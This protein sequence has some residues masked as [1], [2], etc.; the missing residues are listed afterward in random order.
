[1][2]YFDLNLSKEGLLYLDK[3]NLKQIHFMSFF[4]IIIELFMLLFGY[5]VKLPYYYLYSYAILLIS[6]LF[7]YFSTYKGSP[8]FL[9]QIN[10]F[11]E[12]AIYAFTIWGVIVAAFDVNRGYSPFVYLINISFITC[13]FIFRPISA[14]LYSLI[15][16][17]IFSLVF[18]YID[19]LTI[20]IIV[21][22]SLFHFVMF[23]I[24]VGR[25]RA[26]ESN[27][28]D[29]VNL[30]KANKELQILSTIDQLSGCKNRRGLNYEIKKYENQVVFA[31]LADIDN[32]K[33]LNDNYGHDIG[34]LFLS[35]FAKILQS[36]F[37]VSNVFRIGGDEFFIITNS[38]TLQSC[39]KKFE[40]SR[41]EISSISFV[42]NTEL[43]ITISAGYTYKVLSG[44]DG[45]EIMYKDLDIALYKSKAKGKN[46]VTKADDYI[47]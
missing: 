45:F 47:I 29:K 15:N 4:V 43:N 28:K 11:L 38:E 24:C 8:Q 44:N 21:N 14:L 41:K 12:I 5:I 17:T 25:Y 46:Y 40:I 31:L 36:N 23:L 27:Y 22:F 20:D 13:F 26:F 2:H 42:K 39:L 37:G 32:F 7:F 33:Q 6:V 19:K 9:K 35:N 16:A 30:K 34:D 3:T 10:P 1:M 18:I